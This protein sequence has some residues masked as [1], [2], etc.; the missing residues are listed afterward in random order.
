MSQVAFT[1]QECKRLVFPVGLGDGF[2]DLRWLNVP[3]EVKEPRNGLLKRPWY[4]D[5]RIS[6]VMKRKTE[7]ELWL[8]DG[9]KGRLSG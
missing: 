8:R 6:G 2:R 5:T 1:L 7:C 9:G 3:Q 4:R